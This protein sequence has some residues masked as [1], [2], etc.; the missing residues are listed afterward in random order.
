MLTYILSVMLSMQKKVEE[1]NEDHEEEEEEEE[2][3]MDLLGDYPPNVK[4]RVMALRA[5]HTE[6]EAIEE[7]YRK[8]RIELEKK[9]NAKKQT[10]YEKRQPIITGEVE[11]PKGEN[12][13]GKSILSTSLV[14]IG[15]EESY[16]LFYSG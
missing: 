14:V 5:L 1:E 3:E 2:G 13:E 7:E 4:R 16:R 15:R 9:F 10:Y 11:V 6:M 12:E 8:E